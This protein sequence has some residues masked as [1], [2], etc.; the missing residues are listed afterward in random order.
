M[1][2]V[3]RCSPGFT[4][5]ELLVV[6][7]I[8]TI[9][10][11]LLVPALNRSRLAARVAD[12]QGEL[13]SLQTAIELFQ[14]EFGFLPPVTE[15]INPQDPTSATRY[16]VSINGKFLDPDYLKT[17]NRSDLNGGENW[18][19][20]R[21]HRAGSSW[22][23]ED[24]DTDDACTARDLLQNS[25]TEIDLPEFLYYMLCIQFV[26]TDANNR[27]VGV[28]RVTDNSFSPARVRIHYAKSASSGPYAELPG[29]R[30]GDLDGDEFPEVLDSFA[31]PIIFSVGLRTRGAAELCS[32]GPDGK[33][34]FVDLDNNGRW[35]SN[36]PAD[37]GLDDDN[38]GLVDEK[39]DAT[40]TPELTDD[41]VTWD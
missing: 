13:R 30:V 29:S 24:D 23:W 8:I 12:S 22:V 18:L 41:I 16:D 4:L 27:A 9:L 26:P 37:N 36:E 11:A 39:D 19:L 31:N 6:I 10:A 14:N 1:T 34:D 20:V 38:D 5:V 3:R 33:L 25:T 35:D 21:V 17:G 40:H 7:A 2:R 28:F 32:L 15:L